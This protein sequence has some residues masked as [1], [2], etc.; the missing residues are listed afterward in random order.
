[1]VDEDLVVVAANT[2]LLATLGVVRERITGRTL[3]ELVAEL[4]DAPGLVDAV[5][6]ALAGRP[7]RE[8][9]VVSPKAGATL[10]RRLRIGLSELPW[11]TD[12]RRLVLLSVEERAQ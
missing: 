11:E 4:W 10:R 8:E 7:F 2:S 5:R 1:M 6:D 3:D 12:A 9:T